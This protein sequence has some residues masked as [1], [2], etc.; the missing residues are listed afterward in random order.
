[1]K[2]AGVFAV[3]LATEPLRN[4][5][6]QEATPEVDPY[7]ESDAANRRALTA[8]DREQQAAITLVSPRIIGFLEYREDIAILPDRDKVRAV[9]AD[10]EGVYGFA[11][12]AGCTFEFAKPY[13]GDRIALD[14][15]NEEFNV[16]FH[17][18]GETDELPYGLRIDRTVGRAAG[19]EQLPLP[20]GEVSATHYALD[21]VTHEGQTLECQD[22]GD[23]TKEALT[24]A[25][26]T[27]EDAAERAIDEAED[28]FDKAKDWLNNR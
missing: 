18:V 25:R 8:I 13:L 27:I 16:Y 3:F 20:G 21:E 15:T 2:G 12:N 5:T 11:S 28:L 6:S 26:E 24:E 23:K 9:I 19:E 4:V 7:A 10:N 1:M 14:R 17:P 22:L